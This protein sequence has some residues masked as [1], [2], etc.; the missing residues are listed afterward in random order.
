MFHNI[1]SGQ[2]RDFVEFYEQDN[3]TSSDPWNEPVGRTKV[4]DAR[5]DC[6]VRRGDQNSSYGTEVTSEIVTMLMWLDERAENDQVVVWN[7]KE[8][9]VIHVKPD[10]GDKSMI[11]TVRLISK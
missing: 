1:R 11:V 3:D 2:M 9:T 7:G 6:M 10:S 8:Y 5:A 4:F